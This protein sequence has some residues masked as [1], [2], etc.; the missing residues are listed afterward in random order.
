MVVVAGVTL[1][2]VARAILGVVGVSRVAG[3]SRVAKLLPRRQRQRAARETPE[4]R[5]NQHQQRLARQIVVIQTR[6]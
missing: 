3:A 6:R 5:R 4:S 2:A 1:V